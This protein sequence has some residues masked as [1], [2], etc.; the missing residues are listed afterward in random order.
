VA[1]VKVAD[2]FAGTIAAL[3]DGVVAVVNRP[4]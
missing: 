4:K 3:P 1:I 2:R